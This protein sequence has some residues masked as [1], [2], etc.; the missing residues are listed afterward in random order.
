MIKRAKSYNS[1]NYKGKLAFMITRE[2]ASTHDNAWQREKSN[3]IRPGT[4][5][6]QAAASYAAS[7][8]KWI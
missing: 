8:L 5:Q 1:Y 2:K 3:Q 4:E 7:E 6:A